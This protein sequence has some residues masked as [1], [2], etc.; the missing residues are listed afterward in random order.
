MKKGKCKQAEIA[1]HTHDIIAY[2]RC[3]RKWLFSSPFKMHL[4]PKPQFNGVNKNLWFGS[5]FHFAMEDYH[6]WNRF[7][8]PVEAF[9][10]YTECFTEEERPIEFDDLVPLGI[11]M[12]SYY[13]GW[14]KEFANWET[15]WHADGKYMRKSEIPSDAKEVRPLVEEK[16]SLVLEPLCHYKNGKEIFTFVEPG[17]YVDEHGECWPEDSLK[18]AM[19]EYVEIVYHGTFDRICIDKDNRWWVLDYKTAAA[20]D[21]A[22]LDKD[23]QIS[24][25]CWAAEQWYEHEIDG[26]LYVQCSK[27]PPKAPKITS[28]GVS[29]D[30]RQKT[31]ASLYRE[32]LVDYYGSLSDSP[33]ACIDMLNMLEDK[34]SDNGDD[35]IR[36]D[37]VPRNEFHKQRTY[38]YII[39]VGKEILNPS[40]IL[41]PNPTRDCAWDCPFQAMCV[42]MDEGADWEYYIDEFEVRNETMND[43]VPRWEK[44]LYSKYRELYP[45]EFKKTTK[46]ETTLEEF[47]GGS[48]E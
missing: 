4:Q 12:L 37:Y 29:T 31:T 48:N 6:G 8:S 22:K 33:E 9:L 1:M 14:E 30:K 40:T 23:F 35:F 38:E 44:N 42:A 15:L 19:Y 25:Y 5:G 32:A 24:A 7:K 46:H 21:T 10:A 26:M 47:L 41:Y 34:K 3:R 16:F 17:L 43:E 28:K 13:E 20:I 39:A 2:K 18:S 36:Y 45:E 27:N 11:N